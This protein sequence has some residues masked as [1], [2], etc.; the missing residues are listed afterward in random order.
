MAWLDSGGQRSRLQQ[1]VEVAKV[2]TSTVVFYFIL[3]LFYSLLLFVMLS[4]C[5][6]IVKL[7]YYCFTYHICLHISRQFLA[8]FWRLS[9][10]GRLIR[11]S[12]HTARV[13][14]QHDAYL[15]A[16]LTVCVPHTA[17]TISRSLGL[18]GCV[19]ESTS[20]GF[21]MTM[22]THRLVLLL[23]HSQPL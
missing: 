7:L 16:T 8:Q 15:S 9:C 21:W 18:R 6:V 17:W 23:L 10:G 3:S 19:G 14:S 1:A 12:C 5:I 13:N 2:T 22:H 4:F 11:G 20:A